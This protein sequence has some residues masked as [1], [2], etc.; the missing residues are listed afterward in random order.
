MNYV[1][2]Y[3]CCAGRSPNKSQEMKALWTTCSVAVI[4]SDMLILIISHVAYCCFLFLFWFSFVN[5]HSLILLHVHIAHFHVY[6]NILLS[7][8]LI[9]TVYYGFVFYIGE[10]KLQRQHHTELYEFL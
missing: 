8:P 2:R 5:D 4:T 7:V 1:H 3:G 6:I 10:T 9:I